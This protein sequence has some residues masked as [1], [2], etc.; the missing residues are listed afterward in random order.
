MARLS[1]GDQKALLRFLRGIYSNLDSEEFARRAT[2]GLPRLVSADRASYNEWFRKAG[3]FRAF[4]EPGSRDLDG[5]LGDALSRHGHE[6]PL[7][8][9]FRQ[10][11]RTD[12]CSFSDFV[13]TP[14]LH[15]LPL[16]NEYYRHVEV[17][18]QIIVPLFSK[19]TSPSEAG[20]ALSR[21]RRDFSAR[22][23]SVLEILRPHLVQAYFNARAIT[24]LRA[25]RDRLEDVV[26][27]PG[28]AVLGVSAAGSISFATPG[29]RSLLREFFGNDGRSRQVP[30]PLAEWVRSETALR[31]A[32]AALASPRRPF[33]AI[34]GNRTLAVRLVGS[35]EGLW[36]VLEPR[37]E[38]GP[39]AASLAPLGLTP[40]QS[41]VLAWLAHGKS[42][43]EIGTLVGAR[44]AT[45]AKHLERIYQRL[46]VE[47]RTAAAARAFRASGA[48]A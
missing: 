31:E 36:L 37:A 16:Y 47:S 28:R 3:K 38:A 6:N 1:S 26:R 2:R 12:V 40:R 7:L 9:H 5:R 34:R 13:T 4:I 33:V 15:R 44:P 20:F 48:G 17:E 42:N 8:R 39:E 35:E 46:G 19:S 45:V 18:H 22:D 25:E 32:D 43:E 11:G 29:A 30:A 21:R 23:R 27:L 41:E 24:R 14:Q 10:T